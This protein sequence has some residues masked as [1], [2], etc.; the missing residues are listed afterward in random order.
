MKILTRK[1]QKQATDILIRLDDLFS[2][3]MQK[4]DPENWYVPYMGDFVKL[5]E[6]IG[7]DREHQRFIDHLDEKNGETHEDHQTRRPA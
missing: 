5:M 1:K 4:P 7:D 6:L 3:R 2:K